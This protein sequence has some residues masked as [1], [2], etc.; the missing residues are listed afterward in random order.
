MHWVSFAILLYCVTAFQSAVVP[1][2]AVHTIEPDLM[3]IVAIYYALTARS[4]DA[5]LACWTI[6]L[7]IDL[8]SLSY[9][10]NGNVGLHALSLGLM[11]LLIIKV[12][13][14]TFRESVLTHLVITFGATML[15][16]VA[17]GCHLMWAQDDW[18]RTGA[19]ATAAF[20]TSVYTG[21][22]APYGH[23]CLRRVRGILGIGPTHRLRA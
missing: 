10:C 17:T 1:L 7:V 18:S 6:G 14:Y 13:A 23:W 5:L 8:A 4:R 15:V 20:Y 22:L 11:G 19:V 9:R 2:V 16:S 21:V 3:M 12:R